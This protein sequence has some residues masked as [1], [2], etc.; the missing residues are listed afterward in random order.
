MFEEGL[1]V[2]LS[3]SPHDSFSCAS[4]PVSSHPLRG[5]LKGITVGRKR[6]PRREAM[7]DLD[8]RGKGQLMY[9]PTKYVV[10]ILMSSHGPFPQ[11]QG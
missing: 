2:R 9:I 6:T 8:A 3:F 1:V 7:A 5:I 10:C 11:I 4:Q